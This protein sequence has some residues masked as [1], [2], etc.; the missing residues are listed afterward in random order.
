[1]ADANIVVVAVVVQ[2][3]L[4]MPIRCRCEYCCCLLLRLFNIRY[5]GIYVAA[6]IIVIVAVVV[7]YSLFRHIRGRYDY[8]CCRR[9]CSISIIYAYQ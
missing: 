8:C 6:I 3:S 9:C 1:M 2:H 4:F 5:L 7:Q